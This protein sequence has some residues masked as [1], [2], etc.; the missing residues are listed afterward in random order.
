MAILVNC[1]NCGADIYKSPCFLKRSKNLFCGNECRVDFM[2]GKGTGKDNPN[3][4]RKW[5]EDRKKRQSEIIK[6]KVDDKYRL[7]CAKGRKGKDVSEGTKQQRKK[8]MIERYG[9]LSAI[10]DIGHSYEAKDKIG[11][12]SKEK[13]TDEFRKKFYV[14]MVEKGIWM[15]RESKDPYHFYRSLA[16]WNYN[17]LDYDVIGS[18]LFYKFGFFHIKNNTKGMVRDHRFSRLSGFRNLIFPEIVRHPFNCE[19]I[20]HGDNSRKHHN[21]KISSDSITMEELFEGIKKYT[22]DY[23]EQLICLEKIKKYEQGFRYDPNDY[24][25]NY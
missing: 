16:N 24:L 4:G 12:R 8:T 17:V 5:D 14:N 13:F 15:Q 19:I 21:K 6:S 7:N 10:Q 1:S 2:K 22:K 18:D 11:K 20:Q 25:K 9:K 23:P 3:F